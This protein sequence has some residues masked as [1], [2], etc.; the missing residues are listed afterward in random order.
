M[1]L[2]GSSRARLALFLAFVIV[3]F[4]VFLPKESLTRTY[5][6]YY[7]SSYELD[8]TDEVPSAAKANA[9]IFMLIAPSRIH[10]ATLALLNVENRFNRRL[11]YPY[12]LFTANEEENAMITEE[13]RRKIDWITQGRAKFGM[14]INFTPC[15]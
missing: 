11:Q 8:S 5:R 4:L 12:V 15:Y 6:S 7:G 9:V 1:L 10:Q 3:S 13:E 2:S 14:L